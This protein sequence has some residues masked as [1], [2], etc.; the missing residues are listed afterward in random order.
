MQINCSIVDFKKPKTLRG[1]T[2][3]VKNLYKQSIQAQE[4]ISVERAMLLTEFYKNNDINSIPLK[5]AAAFDYI[6]ENKK[7]TIF[8]GELIVGERGELPKATPTYPEI[9][10]H[11]L[12]DLKILNEREKVP[13]KVD[14][15]VFELYKDV[16]IP[17]WS[18]KT[19]REKI[20]SN[21]DKAWLDAFEAG[22]FT[23]FMEQRAP[24]HTV[25]GDR[26][27]KFGMLDIIDQIDQTI[28][29]LK[30]DSDSLSKIEELQAMKIAAKAIIKFARRYAQQA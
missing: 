10:L 4:K 21:M 28:V 13:Y 8:E 5:R 19:I 6:L 11:S 29:D 9:N 3:R 12:K 24:G 16:I 23:E 2:K 17:Y 27:Y 7:V 1:C 18:G 30:N 20:F 26:I 14:K 25:L 22:I 15:E